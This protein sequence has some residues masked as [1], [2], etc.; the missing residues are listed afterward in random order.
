MTDTT[1]QLFRLIA[2]TGPVFR[3][4][5]EFAPAGVKC[6]YGQT[7]DGRLQTTARVADVVL[8]EDEGE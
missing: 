1:P 4:H 6:V 5:R 2:R 3:V 7:L 8:V